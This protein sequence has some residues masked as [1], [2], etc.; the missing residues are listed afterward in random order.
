M[1]EQKPVKC[2]KSAHSFVWW[3][4]EQNVCERRKLRAY[5]TCLFVYAADR[6]RHGVVW[7]LDW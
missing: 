6:R 7:S 3:V 4:W 2:I 1:Y 5:S